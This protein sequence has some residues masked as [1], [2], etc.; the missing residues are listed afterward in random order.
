MSGAAPAALLRSLLRAQRRQP[1]EAQARKEHQ[2]VVQ[3]EREARQHAPSHP[4]RPGSSPR[5]PG[6]RRRSTRK[7]GPLPRRAASGPEREQRQREK[8]RAAVAERHPRAVVA[9]RLDGALSVDAV[10]EGQQ[11]RQEAPS[12]LRERHRLAARPSASASRR[13]RYSAECGI[14][15][16][17]RNDLRAREQQRQ[18]DAAASGRADGPH[19]LGPAARE[20]LP[21]KEQPAGGTGVERALGMS[22]AEGEPERGRR[23]SDRAA[24]RRRAPAGE[25]P[26]AAAESSPSTARRS[27][28]SRT[29]CRSRIPTRPRRSARAAPRDRAPGRREIRTAGPGRA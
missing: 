7:R 16:G 1:G 14:D 10:R 4:S 28:R 25:A 6:L 13:A 21:Q 15:S 19:D 17:Q 20:E 23:Q 3:S 8:N 29:R 2:S 26:A 9:R 11:V 22:P 12:R 24:P 18:R 27:I 5:R